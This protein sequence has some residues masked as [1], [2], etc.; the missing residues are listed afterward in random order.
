MALYAA[1]PGAGH[2]AAIE[3]TAVI[4]P[5]RRAS[6]PGNTAFV[7]AIALKTLISNMSRST[8]SAVS[9]AALDCEPPATWNR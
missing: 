2:F 9:S 7:S 5:V 1:W 6:M 8:S 4:T 3:H